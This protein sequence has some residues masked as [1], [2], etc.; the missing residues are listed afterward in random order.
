MRRLDQL[1]MNYVSL[2]PGS[3]CREDALEVGE[4]VDDAEKDGGEGGDFDSPGMKK[5]HPHKTHRRTTHEH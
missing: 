2:C 1:G 4:L 3:T 5:A